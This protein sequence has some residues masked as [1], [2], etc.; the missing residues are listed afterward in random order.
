MRDFELWF[1][2][3]FFVVLPVLQAIFRKISEIQKAARNRVEQLEEEPT[4]DWFDESA[5]EEV[6]D[7]N[8]PATS[9]PE[10]R[11]LD[12]S[13]IEGP[14][15]VTIPGTSSSAAT[16]RARPPQVPTRRSGPNLLPTSP[17]PPASPSADDPFAITSDEPKSRPNVLQTGSELQKAVIWSEI[18]GKPRALRPHGEESNG[19][20]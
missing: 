1:F 9:P 11:P 14:V 17:I 5:W 20:I 19:T 12:P 10:V 8:R 2:I 6:A 3:I 7:E 16:V 18:L 4:P 15:I 13:E